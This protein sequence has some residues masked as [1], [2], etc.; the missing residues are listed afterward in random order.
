[1]DLK[2][3]II[4]ILL[5]GALLVAGIGLK[6]LQLGLAALAAEFVASLMSSTLAFALFPLLLVALMLFAAPRQVSASAAPASGPVYTVT[7]LSGVHAGMVFRLSESS[8]PLSFGRE[9][10][11]V[12]F[13]GN[14]PGISRKHCV[15][16]L[17]NGQ[18]YLCDSGSHYGS[19][20]LSPSPQR[21]SPGH[22]V[23]LADNACFCLA[24]R[25]LSYR[26]NRSI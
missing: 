1:M 11:D 3:L 10:C 22:P 2:S 14:T 4:G 19:F 7:G 15:I 26:I 13:P 6:N 25:D 17:K 5:G 8:G 12:L 21:L 9:G 24:H 16:Q 23:L 20:I 18:P